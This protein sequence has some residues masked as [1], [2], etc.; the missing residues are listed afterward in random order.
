M[1]GLSEFTHLLIEF[2]R[3]HKC[4]LNWHET[5][6]EWIARELEGQAMTDRDDTEP[7]IIHAPF[8]AEQVAGLNAFQSSGTAHPFTCGGG[9]GETQDDRV[10]VAGTDGWT[11]RGCGY[12]QEWALA[13]MADGSFLH[14]HDEEMTL[15]DICAR[16]IPMGDTDQCDKCGIVSCCGHLEGG[17][18]PECVLR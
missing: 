13:A 15:C 14:A 18:C 7:E 17:L 9:H 1:S 12:T 5:V 11:C 3:T 10:L 4:S 8:S 16:E 6:V 2:T